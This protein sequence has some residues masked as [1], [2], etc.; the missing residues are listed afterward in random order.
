MDPKSMMVHF[1]R[2]KLFKEEKKLGE[3]VKAFKRSL[4]VNPDY[5]DAYYELADIYFS[6]NEKDAAL[7][8]IEKGLAKDPE[9]K[10]LEQIQTKIKVS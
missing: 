7:K 4:S 9:N 6:K 2:G 5:I 10:K 3:A 1:N 8:I